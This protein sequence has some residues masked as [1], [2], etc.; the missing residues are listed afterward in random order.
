[1]T[2]STFALS[3]LREAQRIGSITKEYIRAGLDELAADGARRAAHHGNRWLAYV[4][5]L[6]PVYLANVFMGDSE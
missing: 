6:P 1:M 2:V 3:E 4:D 5:G